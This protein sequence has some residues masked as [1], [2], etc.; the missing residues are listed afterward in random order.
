MFIGYQRDRGRF[1]DVA[2]IDCR[3]TDESKRIRVYGH[4][5]EHVFEGRIILE[6]IV[7]TNDRK[8]YVKFP[9]RAFDSELRGEVRNIFEVLD[10][11]H[12]VVD[13]GAPTY[14]TAK[15]G[16]TVERVLDPSAARIMPSRPETRLLPDW[17]KV[18]VAVPGQIG[19]FCSHDC[20]RK[21]A[22]AARALLNAG[23]ND[24]CP[25]G[26]G[27]KYKKCCLATDE[28]RVRQS[29]ADRKPQATKDFSAPPP[30]QP[31][32][33]KSKQLSETEIKLNALWE[34]FDALAQPTAEQM[35]DLLGNLLALPPKFT[36]WNGVIHTFARHDH[37]QLPAVFRRIVAGVSHIKGT[38]MAFF[39]WAAAEEFTRKGLM[40]FLPEV[41]AGFCK[42]DHSGWDADALG[43]L[44]DYLLA[45][46]FDAE[47]LELV[48]HFLPAARDGVE[49]GRLMP[50]A[51]AHMC[52][53]IFQLRVGIA[54]RAR[55]DADASAEALAQVL[56]R[57]LEEDV[58]AEAAERAA[59]IICDQRPHSA[60]VRADF[61][62][63][64]GDIGED[65]EAWQECLRLYDTLMG[66]A[67]DAW[68]SDQVPP[69]CSL[70]GLSKILESLYAAHDE[71]Q[72]KTRKN[73]KRDNLLDCLNVAGLDESIAR[74]CRDLLGI[75]L[76][77]ARL[78]LE[79][80]E[81]LLR[82]AQRHQLVF[83]GD[84]AATATEL[85]RLR[86]VL[87]A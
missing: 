16:T 81:A 9:D 34:A 19:I 57:D 33:R 36:E 82:F 80:Y 53:L 5:G 48:E 68:R 38:D 10:A 37:P 50:Y 75:N 44:E 13:D 8:W 61:N 12:R 31:K 83:A 23:R 49:D 14:I 4:L 73:S 65:H 62:M 85:M 17:T 6:K 69:V 56:R 40:E 64:E 70:R 15:F 35:D 52:E 60:W 3:Y 2:N 78:M 39:Y 87:G 79:A 71:T 54:L 74:S 47:T 72:A 51:V 11:K 63:V 25:C 67:R 43:H 29:S 7:W 86:G 21:Y 18:I 41:A 45:A 58:D 46:H 76:P 24:L 20:S 66:V 30:S 22:S 42:L 32:A 55:A 84:A 1:G 59:V 77:R 27:Q 26:S 28:A